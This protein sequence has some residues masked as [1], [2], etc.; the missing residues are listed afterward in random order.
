[1]IKRRPLIRNPKPAHSV[2]LALF[3]SVSPFFLSCSSVKTE[4]REEVKVR[5]VVDARKTEAGAGVRFS[6]ILE[7]VPPDAT[8]KTEDIAFFDEFEN[9]LSGRPGSRPLPLRCRVLN[10]APEACRFLK[11]KWYTRWLQADDAFDGPTAPNLKV[12]QVRPKKRRRRATAPVIERIAQRLES[13]EYT[14]IAKQ[15]AGD[16]YRALKTFPAITDGLKVVEEKILSPG[17]CAPSELYNFLGLKSEEQMPEAE[18]RDRAIRLYVRADQCAEP[19]KYTD[20]ARFRLALLSIIKKDCV[21]AAPPL[22]RLSSAVMNDYSSRA[23]YWTAWCAR[24]TKNKTAFFDNF[25]ALFEMNPLGFHTLSLS[26]GDSVLSGNLGQ[27]IDPMVQTRSTIDERVNAWI[28]AME[29]MTRRKRKDLVLKLLTPVQPRLE[30]LSQLEPGVR[31]YLASFAY[32]AG[33]PVA[34]FRLLDSVFRSKAEYVVDKTL[35]LFYP[36]EFFDLVVK[37]A[38]RVN[39][40]L[41]ASLIRQE[42]AFR[43]NARSPVGALGLMQLMPATARTM[44]R[45]ISKRKIL[46]AETN[47]RLGIQYFEMLTKRFDG[48]V[49]LALASYNAGPEAVDRW[50]ARYPVDNRMLFLDLIPYAETRN[51]VT[52]IGRNYFWYHRLYRKLI[53]EKF[54]VASLSPAEFSAFGAL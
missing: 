53:L 20:N 40:I 48:D 19:T 47:I 33:N 41:I 23:R 49:E 11:P 21:T 45:G 4:I 26:D 1:M 36:L 42:S 15:R 10:G 32:R 54:G 5:R 52:L 22:Q 7:S 34:L 14:P 28:Q 29:E 31:L 9:A 43:A 13:G 24:E 6:A 25:D 46:D 8:I 18:F 16:Y 51:Y 35:Q 37:H 50:R 3:L 2:S 44:Q 17:V 39:P 38:G 27:E 12:S 30:E